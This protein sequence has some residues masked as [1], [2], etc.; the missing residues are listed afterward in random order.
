LGLP[1]R[2]TVSRRTVESD[3]FE[4]KARWEAD[5]QMVPAAALEETIAEILARG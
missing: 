3:A 1:V 5:R 2:V 4:L